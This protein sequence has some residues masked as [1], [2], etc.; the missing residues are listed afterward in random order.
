MIINQLKEARSAFDKYLRAVQY[1]TLR[2]Y[3]KF[4]YLL[5]S[6]HAL[7]PSLDSLVLRGRA[8]KSPAPGRA[9]KSLPFI[10]NT[11]AG[12]NFVE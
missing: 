9:G 3:R 2:I 4:T 11:G 8:G 7:A 5:D 1:Q 12:A 10:S 6:P